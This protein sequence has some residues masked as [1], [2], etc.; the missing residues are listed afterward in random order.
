MITCGTDKLIVIR[1]V[2]IQPGGQVAS[3]RV[4]QIASQFGPNNFDV[5]TDGKIVTACQDRQIRTYSETGKIINTVKG[6]LCEE[7]TLT[8]V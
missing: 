8:K 5:T 7:G 3:K 4:N 2:F 6:T 1:H